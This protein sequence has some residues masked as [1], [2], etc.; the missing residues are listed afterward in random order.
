M[1]AEARLKNKTR[2]KGAGGQGKMGECVTPEGAQIR[3]ISEKI[4]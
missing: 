2:E 3:K 4:G 1:R